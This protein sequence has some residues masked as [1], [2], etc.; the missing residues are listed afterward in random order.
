MDPSLGAAGFRRHKRHHAVAKV[1][2]SALSI[3][4]TN[5]EE[6]SKLESVPVIKRFGLNNSEQS[7]TEDTA[8]LSIAG[9]YGTDI[10]LLSPTPS[11]PSDLFTNPN[12]SNAP[13]AQHEHNPLKPR[14][15]KLKLHVSRGALAKAQR[16]SPS[17][18]PTPN[19]RPRQPSQGSICERWMKALSFCEQEPS[20][21]TTA[22]TTTT[23]PGNPMPA[24]PPTA[25]WSSRRWDRYFHPGET[26]S[27]SSTSPPVRRRTRSESLGNL[28]S[29]SN[30]VNVGDSRVF[31]RLKKRRA[32]DL[33]GC[34]MA[35]EAGEERFSTP[36]ESV[37]MRGD[38]REE[39]VVGEVG[40]A[41]M[42]DGSMSGLDRDQSHESRPRGFRGRMSGWMRSAKRSIVGSLVGTRG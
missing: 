17:R 3:P 10:E 6:V 14:H 31:R 4:E 15:S 7:S 33:G 38:S 41:E 40:K 36:P 18:C 37:A 32:P 30:S 8:A 19:R 2:L 28:F 11:S 34:Q 22:T 24:V 25:S 16:H 1:R 39:A 20:S 12:F 13:A 23:T 27:S 9:N 26:L 21:T 42:G 35:E 5:T 29:R